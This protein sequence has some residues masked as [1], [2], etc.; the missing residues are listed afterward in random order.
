MNAK[1]VFYVPYTTATSPLDGRCICNAYWVIHPTLGLAFY[2][3]GASPQC[4]TDERVTR[5]IA[6][7]IYPG[8]EVQRVGAVYMAHAEDELARLKERRS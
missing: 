7:K 3:D 1:K 8:H 4:N 6:K 5:S 2:G